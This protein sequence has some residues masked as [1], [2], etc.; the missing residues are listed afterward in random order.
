M[1]LV[2]DNFHHLLLSQ[3][4]FSFVCSSA[5][6]GGHQFLSVLAARTTSAGAS[7]HKKVTE[8]DLPLVYCPR[9]FYKAFI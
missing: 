1:T 6:L 7:H 8:T 4:Y 2:V 5:G 9:R 3:A